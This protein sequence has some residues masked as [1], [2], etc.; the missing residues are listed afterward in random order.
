MGFVGPVSSTFNLVCGFVLNAKIVKKQP[1]FHAL[2][3]KI[4]HWLT[5]C[6]GIHALIKCVHIR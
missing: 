2:N 4:V 6:V 5:L 3:A 1:H